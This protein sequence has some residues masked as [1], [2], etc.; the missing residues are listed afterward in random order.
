M[1][2]KFVCTMTGRLA[3]CRTVRVKD[4][5]VTVKKGRGLEGRKL[6]TVATEVVGRELNIWWEEERPPGLLSERWR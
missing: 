2:E 1:F 4:A 6:K 3:R 5:L